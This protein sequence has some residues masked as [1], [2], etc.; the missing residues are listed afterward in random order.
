MMPEIRGRVM[1]IQNI[2]LIIWD[3][4]ETFW[5]GTISEGS[6]DIPFRNLEIIKKTTD[7]GIVN[8]ICSKN[9]LSVV[10]QQLTDLG[11]WDYFVFPSINW[12]AKGNR[13][14]DIIDTMKLRYVNVLFV[15]DNVQN[16]EEAKHFCPGLMT[17]LPDKLQDLYIMIDKSGKTD[18]DHKRLQQYHLLEKKEA[19]RSEFSSNDEFLVS[20]NIKVSI[21]YD[22]I[23]HLDRIYDL[24]IRSNQ[25]N[26]TKVRPQKNELEQLFYN[27]EMKCGYVSVQDKFGDYGIIGFFALCGTTAEHFAFS[28]RTLGMQVEQYV[29]MTLGCPKIHVSGNV[30]AE[31]RADF[32]PPWINQNQLRTK[33]VQKEEIHSAKILIKG[34]CDMSQMYSFLDC[35]KNLTTEFSYTNEQGVLTEGHNHTSQ[36]VTALKATDCDKKTILADGTFFD[37]GMLNTALQNEKFDFVVLSMLTDGNLGTYIHDKTSYEVALCEKQYDLTDG[38]RLKQ[39]ISGS[40]FTSGIKFS[41]DILSN[42][43]KKFTCTTDTTWKK[44]V[45]NLEFINSFIGHDT[46]LILLLGSEQ[47]FS[48]KCNASYE[49]RHIEHANMNREITVWAQNQPNVILIH[50]DKYIHNSNDFVDT[51]NHFSK[52]VYYDLALDLVKIFKDNSKSDVKVKGK[53]DLYIAIVAQKLRYAKR[54]LLDFMQKINKGL[55]KG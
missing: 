50:Y 45:D 14:K 15:D 27:P 30:V 54:W 36:I 37:A 13:V 43:K 44:T 10:Q 51:I 9:D 25:L 12:A 32:I 52:R 4:D 11:I 23:N 5:N 16:L 46:K 7:M 3:L 53:R 20:C 48:G 39:Y 18:L 28:C 26:Y 47:K 22:C 19:L 8:S 21:A 41:E 29:Y 49:N 1:D 40:I 42:F 2:K 34:P 24:L 17:A 55:K 31:L 33:E 35:C 6:V 38:E